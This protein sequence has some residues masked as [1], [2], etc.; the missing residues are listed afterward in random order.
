MLELSS[1]WGWGDDYFYFERLNK[2]NIPNK[3]IRHI[4]TLNI[5]VCSKLI[6]VHWIVVQSTCHHSLTQI[7]YTQDCFGLTSWFLSSD[8]VSPEELIWID[9][10][11]MIRAWSLEESSLYLDIISVDVWW[12]ERA[13]IA[14]LAYHTAACLQI[15]TI[16]LDFP[17]FACQSLSIYYFI[18]TD[19]Y[20]N[21]WQGI[22]CIN[23]PHV[24]W[25]R[26]SPCWVLLL[27]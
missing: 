21:W 25:L 6:S 8:T 13:L 10:L 4:N 27:R 7:S 17:L 20:K 2:T 23:F 12:K 19:V 18:H 11:S 26:R 15:C 1:L 16:I 14:E 22:W 5:Y 3:N 9:Y 24:K